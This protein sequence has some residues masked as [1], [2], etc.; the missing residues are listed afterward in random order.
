VALAVRIGGAIRP[1]KASATI[2][3]TGSVADLLAAARRAEDGGYHRIKVKIKPG[4]DVE[5]L[6]ALRTELPHMPVLADANGAY[7]PEDLD[8]L[9]GF[10]RFGLM[11]LE[12]PMAAHNW[13]AYAALQSRL[14][15]TVCLD[16]SIHTME[17]VDDLLERR[18]ARAV[19]IKVGRVGG[20]I[21]ARAIHDRLA[22]EGIGCF[23]GAKFETGIGRWTNIALATLPGMTYP[24]DVA[25]SA[26]YFA[27]DITTL[28]VEL[29]GRGLVAPLDAPGLGGHQA[30]NAGTTRRVHAL[31][32]RTDAD[33]C[34]RHSRAIVDRHRHGAH[35][36]HDHAIADGMAGPPRGLDH[37]AHLVGTAI[38]AG[39][40]FG[41]GRNHLGHLFIAQCGEQGERPRGNAQR[42]PP[43]YIKAEGADGKGAFHAVDAQRIHAA[44]HEQIDRIAGLL[45]Q[46]LQRGT[47]N[48]TNAETVRCRR[49]EQKQLEPQMV[50][51]GIGGLVDQTLLLQ[52]REQPV[53][54][55]FVQPGRACNLGQPRPFAH[56]AGEDAEDC[57]GTRHTL[58]VT[59]IGRAPCRRRCIPTMATLAAGN[60]RQLLDTRHP[61]HAPVLH[62]D[63]SRRDRGRRS[64][65]PR[66][67]DDPCQTTMGFALAERRA[68]R[69]SDA[70]RQRT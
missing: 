66:R 36:G 43:P 5:P 4:W 30:H 22:A 19:N 64:D 63:R 37:P 44:A 47:G 34:H 60:P 32:D 53:G 12:Q 40:A 11:L 33:R 28:P 54:R 1:V 20:L 3:V 50:A 38:E 65:E 6:S 58:H 18:A 67:Y 56:M 59:G 49:A 57:G 17:D 21:R 68:L 24:S 13:K 9:A 46:T 41:I 35:A 29:T 2:G 61:V 42:P 25:E 62:S 70:N 15:T 14:D 39:E 27:P 48:V 23:T 51:V 45:R 8:H 10:D 55:R 26:R 16:E 52:G 7:G 31:T 69:R